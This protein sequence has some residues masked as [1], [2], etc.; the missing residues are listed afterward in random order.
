[1]RKQLFDVGTLCLGNYISTIITISIHQEEAI[2]MSLQ[3]DYS[4]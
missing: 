4:K 3:T 2:S 1:M